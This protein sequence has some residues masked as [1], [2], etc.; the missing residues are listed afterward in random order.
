MHRCAAGRF[1]SST[2]NVKPTCAVCFESFQT[3]HALDHHAK[4][5][6][7]QAYKCACGTDFN[8][9]SALQ[10]HINTKDAPKTF[11]C[12]LCYDK[13]TRKDKLK[14]HC[15][16]YHKIT[17]EGLRS[18]FDAQES[19][20]RGAALRR[21]APVP[22]AAA[23]SE[24]APT[25]APAL[26]TALAPAPASAGPAFWSFAAAT[27]QQDADFLTGSS[28][29]AGSF[30]PANPFDPAADFFSAAAAPTPSEDISGLAGG[31]LGDEA[32]ATVFDDFNF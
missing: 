7:H 16:H 17:A 11:A 20:P 8:K 10:R 28:V 9:N 30:V 18:L 25:Q 12:T 23:A 1:V 24:P 19:R 31:F 22:L 3:A 14:D 21:R 26:P 6:S 32:W 13:F 29:P 2:A 5:A 27:G 4:E 15:R